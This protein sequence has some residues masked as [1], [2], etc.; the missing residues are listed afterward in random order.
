MSLLACFLPCRA[1]LSAGVGLRVEKGSPCVQW[2]SPR[3]FCCV[4]GLPPHSALF[5]PSCLARPPSCR[6]ASARKQVLAFFRRQIFHLCDVSG[7]SGRENVKI[8]V[9][10]SDW[11]GDFFIAGA[12]RGMIVACGIDSSGLRS[13]CFFPVCMINAKGGGELHP[14]G[15]ESGLGR[16]VDLPGHRTVPQGQINMRAPENVVPLL[17]WLGKRYWS[18]P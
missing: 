9:N 18:I 17:H 4:A 2:V 10:R 3:C 16:Q 13:P 14:G 7:V 5:R 8:V 1:K 6:F 11:D 12:C 15:A